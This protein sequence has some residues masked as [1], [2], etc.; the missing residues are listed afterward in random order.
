M[1]NVSWHEIIKVFDGTGLVKLLRYYGIKALRGNS[2]ISK[3]DLQYVILNL[4]QDLKRFFAGAQNDIKELNDFKKKAGA[5]H[6]DMSGNIRCAAF[7]LAEVLI[8]LAIIGIVAAMTIPTLVS[9]FQD[10]ALVSQFK[11]TYSLLNQALQLTNYQN[12]VEYKCYT[13]KPESGS[14]N[15]Y[16]YSQC[17]EFRD[18][19]FKNLK[20]VK[21]EIVNS[22]PYKSKEEVLAQGGGIT[23]ATCSFAILPNTYKYYLQDGSIIYWYVAVGSSHSA[24]ITVDVNGDKGPN[25]WGY[26]VFYLTPTKRKNGSIR[27]YEAIC[28]IWEN[29]GKRAFNIL[30]DIDVVNDDWLPD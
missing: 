8:T 29:G 6:V 11:K 30:N 21:K 10:K 22:W 27:I 16:E 3:S 19:F 15:Y 18:T 28:T 17:R 14:Q 4:F 24:F 5:T 26:D 20:Y 2:R 12:G 13:N 25:K 1:K 9:K 23:G 7:T